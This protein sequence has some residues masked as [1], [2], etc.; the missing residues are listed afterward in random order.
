MVILFSEYPVTYSNKQQCSGFD[1]TFSLYTL[2]VKS[3][4]ELQCSYRAVINASITFETMFSSSYLRI[5]N[6]DLQ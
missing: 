6:K 1:V 3:I 2:V 5:L 4:D